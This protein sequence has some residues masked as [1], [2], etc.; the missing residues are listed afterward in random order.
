MSVVEIEI[1]MENLFE[2]KIL[3]KASMLLVER[4]EPHP[5]CEKF[6]LNNLQECTF[7]ERPN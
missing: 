6:C 2:L 1:E 4:Q 5:A 7:E 3:N